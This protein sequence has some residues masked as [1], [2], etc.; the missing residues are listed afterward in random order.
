VQSAL[1]VCAPGL[2]GRLRIQQHCHAPNGTVMELL[3]RA[4]VDA[5]LVIERITS[6]GLPVG[7]EIL[8]TVFQTGCFFQAWPNLH[9]YRLSRRAIKMHLCEN[10]RATDANIRVVLFDRYGGKDAAVGRKAA[11]GPLHGLHGHELAALAV[12]VAWTEMHAQPVGAA[13]AG[14][15]Y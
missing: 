3:L 8:E 5:T 12:A 11:P 2:D 9:R 14:P 4:P 10:A 6:F 13:A 7:E 15:R 1:L